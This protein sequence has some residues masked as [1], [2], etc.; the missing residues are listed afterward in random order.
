M[1]VANTELALQYSPWGA[2][3]RM[4]L[5]YHVLKMRQ[6]LVGQYGEWFRYVSWKLR[7]SEA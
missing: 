5:W 3:Q 1:G 6:Q 7:G 4:M 2:Q